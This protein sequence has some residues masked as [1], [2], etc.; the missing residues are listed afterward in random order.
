MAEHA[1]TTTPASATRRR[2]TRPAGGVLDRRSPPAPLAAPFPY[3]PK[4]KV[5]AEV[6]HFFDGIAPQDEVYA[7]MLRGTCM[8]PTINDGDMALVSPIEPPQP[9]DF[10][11][12]APARGGTPWLKR[13]VMAPLIPV[14]T[15]LHPSSDVS[16][17][18]IA[19]ML[20]PH[21]QFMISTDRLV[22]M[23]RV[24]GVIG[25]DEVGAARA[26]VVPVRKSG[27]RRTR[28]AV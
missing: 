22:A 19:E 8:A 6:R 16:P 2:D 18:V 13:L 17:V 21:K 28:E 10:V 26:A 11:L 27:R 20:N 15:R 23:H 9:G 14:G 24:V 4:G 3:K 7:C 5:R 25:K 12:L 1:H